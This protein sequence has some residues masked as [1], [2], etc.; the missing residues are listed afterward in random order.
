MARQEKLA[1]IEVEGGSH[2]DR[3]RFYT[4]LYHALIQPS[5]LS[6]VDGTYPIYD[7]SR[8]FDPKSGGPND[9]DAAYHAFNPAIGHSEVT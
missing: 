3:V 4:N 1:R 9:P 7:P 5:I 2:D 8:P 6:D